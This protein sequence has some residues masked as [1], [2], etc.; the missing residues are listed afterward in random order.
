MPRLAP[1]T[2]T[3]F[4]AAMSCSSVAAARRVRGLRAR[5]V[6]IADTQ[7]TPTS[8]GGTGPV[9]G[10]LTV[11]LCGSRAALTLGDMDDREAARTAVREFLSSRRDRVSP[12]TPASPSAGPAVG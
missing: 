4:V 7:R 10:V 6:S 1:V 8:E 3:T 11:T 5:S 2:R 9:K 12:P